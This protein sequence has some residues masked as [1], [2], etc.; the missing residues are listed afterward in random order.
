MNSF[1]RAMRKPVLAF[2]AMLA[3]YAAPAFAQT[4]VTNVNVTG[5]A[6]V[7]PPSYHKSLDSVAGVAT[8]DTNVVKV[9]VFYRRAGLYWNGTSF[10]LA[11]PPTSPAVASSVF[12]A[13]FN[14]GTNPPMNRTWIKNVNPPLAALNDGDSIEITS[15]ATDNAAVPNTAEDV[16]TIIIDK[17]RPTVAWGTPPAPSGAIFKPFPTLKGTAFDALSGV[18]NV[19]VQIRQVL[20][21]SAG[22]YWD[23][24]AFVTAANLAAAPVLTATLT[25]PTTWTYNSP[26]PLTENGNYDFFAVSTDIASN[27][28]TRADLLNITVDGTPP[29]AAIT[30]VLP[31]ITNATSFP[32]LS[33]TMDDNLGGSKFAAGAVTVEIFRRPIGQQIGAFWNGN[34]YVTSADA[35]YASRKLT[36][37]LTLNTTPLTWTRNPNLSGA[38]LTDGKYNVIVKVTDK[39]G[40]QSQI[41]QVIEFDRVAPAAPIITVPSDGTSIRHL[42]SIRGTTTDVA[43]ANG[44]S[45]GLNVASVNLQIQRDSDD[46]YWNGTGWAAPTTLLTTSMNV[47]N[48]DLSGTWARTQQLPPTQE[49]DGGYTI[50]AVTTDRAGNQSLTATAAVT[51]DTSA[52]SISCDSHF[53]GMTVTDLT[54]IAGT[55]EDIAGI[56]AESGLSVVKVGIYRYAD[57]MT[58]DGTTHQ[59]VALPA[60]PRLTAVGTD[61]WLVS[62]DLPQ[63]GTNAATDLIPSDYQLILEAFDNAGNKGRIILN[64]RV[65]EAPAP[66]QNRLR[67]S[68]TRSSND[69][70]FKDEPSE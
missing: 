56:T 13:T 28:S 4:T 68:A 33:G 17:V 47:A 29:T 7:A 12:V 11:M 70:P 64:L 57:Q 34:T 52:P 58:W 36:A 41:L 5:V 69:E 16:D 15:R 9:E 45:S 55:A 50:T 49:I 38:N 3:S 60:Q 2:G 31:T 10:S 67:P 66:V 32:T 62:D 25:T 54:A 19:K 65:V 23:G 6:I 1:E 27:A 63:P 30:S 14:G 8:D 53:S 51:V 21:P 43:A 44:S 26:T 35:N 22:R 18:S 37:A 61:N 42:E 40:N 20:G 24:N 48:G 46:F 59:W 39:V